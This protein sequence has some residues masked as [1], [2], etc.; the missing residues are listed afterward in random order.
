MKHFALALVPLISFCNIFGQNDLQKEKELLMKTDLEFSRLSEEKGSNEA[1]LTYASD[2]AVL[3]RQNS[4]PVEGKS[5]ITSLL[6]RR[7]DT[8]FVLVWK[9]MFADVASSGEMGYTYG[10][11]EVKTPGGIK[12]I[13]EGTYVTIWKK[14]SKGDW[15]FVLDTGNE[16]LKPK[17]QQK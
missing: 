8:T 3:L 14:D 1:F 10:T 9:P 15:K 13:G 16:G 7:P 4:F 12:T 6:T 2:S 11:F 5:A 17:K